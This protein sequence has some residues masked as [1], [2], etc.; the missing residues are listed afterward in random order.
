MGEEEKINKRFEN[1]PEFKI[2]R[3]T[4]SQKTLEVQMDGK[5]LEGVTAYEIQHSENSNDIFPKTKI[6]LEF[7]NFKSLKIIN[8]SVG[9]K[10]DWNIS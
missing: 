3:D 9:S 10:I 5:I 4:K 1:L 8:H 7:S 2:L 6:I